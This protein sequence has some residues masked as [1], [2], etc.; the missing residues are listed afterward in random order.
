MNYTRRKGLNRVA[1]L[2]TGLI[3]SAS[4]ALAQQPAVLLTLKEATD[5]TL[6]HNRDLGLSK[7]DEKIARAKTTEMDAIWLP[8]VDFSF[9]ALSSNNPLNAF[10]F[11][12]QQQVVQQKDFNPDLL[13]NPGA[14]GDYSGRLQVKQPLLNMDLV[15]MR[16]AVAAQEGIYSLKTKRTAEYLVYEVEKAYGQLQLLYDAEKVLKEAL[17]SANAMYIFTDNRVKEGL[18]QKSDALNVKVWIHTVET[19]LAETG[20]NI[21]NASDFLNLLMGKPYGTVYTAEPVM[22]ENT[23]VANSSIPDDRADFAA[24]KKAM[25]ASRLMIRAAEKSYLPR[26]NAFASYQVN[27]YRLTGFSAGSY[28]AGLQL[29][30]DIFKGNSTKNKIITQ[31]TEL[32]KLNDQLQNQQEQSQLELNKTLR[33][34]EDARFKIR[35]QSAAIENAT[36]ALRI[37]QDRY[38]QGLV[39]STDVLNA[40]TQLSQQQLGKASAV[41]SYNSTAAYIRFLTSTQKN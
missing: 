32:N 41:F 2:I 25:E 21:R 26:I 38:E 15:Y 11:K 3:L 4:G 40:Q 7:L 16:K 10:G 31:Q 19:Q 24:M 6:A 1:G 8:Q 36:E 35:Q 18:M 29:S 22:Q 30:W 9:T 13:N 33:Q 28:L 20:S 14:T 39:N 5:S 27:D 17:R 23:T 34:L 12:M 37:L